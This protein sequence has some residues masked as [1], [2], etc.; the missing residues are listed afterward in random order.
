MAESEDGE[1]GQAEGPTDGHDAIPFFGCGAGVEESDRG[2]AEPGGGESCIDED[3]E[4]VDAVALDGNPHEGEGALLLRIAE[5]EVD[6]SGGAMGGTDSR[7][8][9]QEPLVAM[10]AR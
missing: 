6:P 3:R 7:G 2:T 5:E 9:D 10:E 1:E 8:F 4:A